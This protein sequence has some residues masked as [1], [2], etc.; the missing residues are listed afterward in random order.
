MLLFDTPSI[1]CEKWS[2][3]ISNGPGQKTDEIT[4]SQ[5]TVT[6]NIT[7]QQNMKNT[8]S[9][10]HIAYTTVQVLIYSTQMKYG[11]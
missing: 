2:G 4:H 11:S 10:H 1:E 8:T 6:V 5:T 9:K 7:L 3:A